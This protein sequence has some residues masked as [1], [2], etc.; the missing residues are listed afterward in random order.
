MLKDKLFSIGEDVLK[1]AENDGTEVMVFGERSALIRFAKSRIH[2]T[3]NVEDIRITIRVRFGKRSS[4]ISFS[5]K[6]ERRDL[7]E[8]VR[9]AENIAKLSPENPDLPELPEGISVEA[10]LDYFDEDMA[11][12]KAGDMVGIAG[13]LIKNTPK[14][15][16]AFGV[17]SGGSTEYVFLTSS[18]FRGYNYLTDAH[19]KYNPIYETFSYIVQKSAKSFKELRVYDIMERVEE[20]LR[21]VLDP[22]DAKPGKW[23]VILEPLAL[24]E[25]IGYM[26][27][28]ALS[29]KSAVEGRSPLKDKLGQKIFSER[30]T[31]LDDPLNPRG[32]IMPFDFE[33]K[34]KGLTPIIE[35]GVFKNFAHNSIT[36][37][38]MG[39]DSNA[40]ALPFTNYPLFM[41]IYLRG[42][43]TDYKNI[44]ENTERGLIITRF[45]YVNLVDVQSLTF[46][47]MTRDGVF[48]VENGKI[49][50]SMKNM[51]FNES[52]FNALN[53][54][55]D[56]SRE[57]EL[58]GESTWY[59]TH[60]PM[61]M[62][63]PT[64]KIKDFNF[65]SPTSF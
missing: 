26:N 49:V 50:G 62:I 37:R 22:M 51:R 25:L 64:V 46:T 39:V 20:R 63:L 21:F 36:A 18:G 48:V 15:F 10:S 54:V 43:N 60:F 12:I 38:K 11:N 19:I 27:W 16:E 40:C 23:T 35:K 9:K 55:L 32:F 42:G 41:N 57:E 17:V 30:I 52:L 13:E 1:V 34:K 53:N 14:P 56:V 29:G 59:D 65:S 31:L 33:G 6:G 4:V 7:V 5:F 44:V 28:V 58:I 61:G 3:T 2:Q 8:A 45:W 24:E 47:G